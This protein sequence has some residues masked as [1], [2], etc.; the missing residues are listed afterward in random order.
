MPRRGGSGGSG[1]LGGLG[2]GSSGS[3]API[4]GYDVSPNNPE[5]YKADEESVT[6]VTTEMPELGTKLEE[7]VEEAAEK[8]T[9]AITDT[10]GLATEGTKDFKDSATVD[11]SMDIAVKAMK[12]ASKK[13]SAEF[14]KEVDAAVE[15][16][17]KDF[18]NLL[19]KAGLKLS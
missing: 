3:M 6:E 8:Q 17:R 18:E 12:D 14:E 11:L 1:G 5:V 2:G 19:I 10:F 15:K 7:G 9:E 16:F 13:E 4:T